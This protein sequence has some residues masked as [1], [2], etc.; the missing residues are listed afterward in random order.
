MRRVTSLI[1]LIAILATSLPLKSSAFT[2]VTDYVINGAQIDAGTLDTIRN[3]KGK[4]RTTEFQ[5]TSSTSSTSG[6]SKKKNKHSARPTTIKAFQA[7]P[8]EVQFEVDNST[9][10]GKSLNDAQA[11][12]S[13]SAFYDAI[14]EA[15]D[16]WNG[17]DIANVM[18]LPPK[19]TT[20]KMDPKDGLNLISARTILAPEGLPQNSI[21]GRAFTV[22]TI[23]KTNSVVFKGKNIMVKPGSILDVD[24]V[25][26]PRNNTCEVF[27]TTVGDITIGGDPNPTIGEG[28]ADPIL[29]EK[30]CNNELSGDDITNS[31]V[32]AISK[33]LGLDTS[34][35]TSSAASEVGINMMRY[36]LTSDDEIGLANIYPNPTALK[37]R[38]KISG[39]VTLKNSPVLGAHVVL[40]NNDTGEATVSAI[41][42]VNGGFEII[43]VPEGDYIVYAEPLDG[44]I[45]PKKFDPQSFFPRNADTNYT[46]GVSDK[47]VSIKAGKE[48]RVVIAAR[49]STGSAFGIN[50]KMVFLFTLQEVDDVGGHARAPI[51]ISPGET[52]SAEFWG[53]NV[54]E[55]FGT[56][57]VS[58]DGCTVSN[59]VNKSVRI[60]DNHTCDDCEDPLDSNNDGILDGPPCNRNPELCPMTQE[61][62]KQADEL[63]GV[64]ADIT[65]AAD[66]LPGPRNIIY[67]A[68][69]LDPE[70]PNFGLRDQISGGLIVRE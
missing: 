20:A 16:L 4:H 8:K 52:Q 9:L 53:I 65:C 6:G 56:L 43:G 13:S 58:G 21:S 26:D 46:T 63:P 55:G 67:T 18:I 48:S 28:G 51:Q 57:T 45:R 41:T 17:V 35:L 61:V 64:S 39:K 36:A 30:T 15:V 10:V 12:I 60:S 50:P 62:T 3:S 22:S 42:D 69:K 66:A 14:L 54:D 59:V 24:T 11:P 37:T 1:L 33:L 44:G 5:T 19:F 40:Q 31:A 23:A 38:G 47:L 70:N 32:L 25:F 34:G 68:D 29:A 49:E 7:N 27:F 2:R